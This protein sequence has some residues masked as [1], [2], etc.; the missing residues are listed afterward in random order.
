MTSPKSLAFPV[1]AISIKSIEL[2]TYTG[3]DGPLPEIRKILVLFAALAKAAEWQ[4]TEFN[5]QGLANTA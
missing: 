2:V 5:A 4:I 3:A 1:V